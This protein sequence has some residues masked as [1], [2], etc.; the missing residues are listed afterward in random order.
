MLC[1]VLIGTMSCSDRAACDRVAA[2]A[3]S[4]TG[5]VATVTAELR[6]RDSAAVGNLLT[7]YAR[8]S[9]FMRDHL[10]DTLSRTDADLLSAY[11]EAGRALSGSPQRRTDLLARTELVLS[12]LKKLSADARERKSAAAQLTVHLET[13]KKAAMELIQAARA[14]AATAK[15]SFAALQNASPGVEEIIRRLNGRQLPT[16]IEKDRTIP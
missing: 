5:V 3:D 8:Y 1:S 4:L 15:T 10:G 9:A 7:Q 11:D 13:E 16:V 6:S 2:S 14:E 12:Q